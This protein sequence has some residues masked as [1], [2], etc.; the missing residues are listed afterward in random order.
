MV[1]ECLVARDIAAL[2]ILDEY[3]NRQGI[4]GRLQ[5]QQLGQSVGRRF[6]AGRARLV[7]EAG[8]DQFDALEIIHGATV[9]RI[10]PDD[11][12]RQFRVPGVEQHDVREAARAH[13]MKTML[14][15]RVGRFPVDRH[16]HGQRRIGLLATA[17][18]AA[19]VG[20]DHRQPGQCRQRRALAETQVE[21]Q[22]AGW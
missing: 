15:V 3:G 2:A 21:E 6:S 16:Q 22:K 1:L 7:L 9:R 5:A 8:D 14:P 4:H 17:A 10:A 19:R 13:R 20:I 12:A 11:A 18:A